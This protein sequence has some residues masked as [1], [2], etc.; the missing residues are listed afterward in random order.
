MTNKEYIA[1]TFRLLDKMKP[2]KGDIGDLQ[3]QRR[4][5]Q[6]MH[7]FTLPPDDRDE[8]SLV[9]RRKKLKGI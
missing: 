2:A 1:E 7:T 6:Y 4:V 5:H 9:I 8:L 3:K